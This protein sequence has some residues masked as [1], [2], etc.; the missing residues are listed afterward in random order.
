[1]EIIW[2][3]LIILIILL[4]ASIIGLKVAERKVKKPTKR[5]KKRVA[6]LQEQLREIRGTS[7]KPPPSRSVRYD[8]SPMDIAMA[9]YKAKEKTYKQKVEYK[10]EW[11]RKRDR[12]EHHV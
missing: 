1:M 6:T 11:K 8:P 9:K 2:T 5:R 7:K 10:E 4:F 12:G 3:V